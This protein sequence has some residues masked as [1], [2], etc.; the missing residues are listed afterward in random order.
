M[1]RKKKLINNSDIPQYAIETVARCLLPDI[2]AY[3]ESEEG[4]REFAYEAHTACDRHG[5][6]LG[7][8]VT[9]GNVHDSVAWDVLYDQVTAKFDTAQYIVMDAGYK[10]PWIAKKILDDG[11]VPILP[12]TNHHYKDGQYRP[13]EYS[14][15]PEADTFTCHHDGVLRHTTT[16]KDGKRV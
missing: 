12:Y 9:A 15:D 2:I 7:V 1:G 14:Y 3:F 10:T 13:W 8:E 16:S 11:R 6:I 4:Q 5:M